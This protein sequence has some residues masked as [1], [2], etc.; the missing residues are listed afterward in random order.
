M[1]KSIVERSAARRRESSPP[2]KASPSPVPLRGASL[3]F[4]PRSVTAS[5]GKSNRKTQL[6]QNIRRVALREASSASQATR[7]A[8]RWL[9][10]AYRCE[11]NVARP[12]SSVPR[13]EDQN[14][15]PKQVRDDSK[16]LFLKARFRHSDKAPGRNLNALASR[17]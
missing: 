3:S 9:E 4:K 15:I 13:R 1:K 6:M 8:K 7:S 11:D 2:V 14:Q 16:W 10:D 5:S 17:F 12:R